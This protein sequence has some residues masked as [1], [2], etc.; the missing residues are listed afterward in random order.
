MDHVEQRRLK[1]YETGDKWRG[2]LLPQIRLQGK[3]LQR[4]GFVPG[5]RLQVQVEPGRLI[6]QTTKT[7]G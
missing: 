7:E 5:S 6:I 2:G 1:V 4:A 3:W